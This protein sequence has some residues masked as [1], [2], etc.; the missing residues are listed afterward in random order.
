MQTC[1]GSHTHTLVPTKDDAD[2][3]RLRL[4]HRRRALG[5]GAGRLLRRR[6]EGEPE[7]RALQHRRDQGAARRAREGARSSTGRASSPTR[8]P[9]PSPACGP[10]AITVPARSAPAPPT[11]ATTSR[12]IPEVGL[13]AGAC[14]GNG[15]LMDISDPANPKR[16]DARRRQELRLLAL[17]DVQQRRHQGDLHRRVGRRHAAALPRDRS[18]Q[19]GRR[20]DLRHRRQEA[21]VRRLLQD[22]GGADRDRRTASRTTAR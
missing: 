19:L 9:A 4:G 14:S 12:C 17:G 20:R 13:A 15:I 2:A 1:R 5:R 6:S 7:H 18:A 10:A 16:L 3:L 22:A 11:S 21:D 8:R